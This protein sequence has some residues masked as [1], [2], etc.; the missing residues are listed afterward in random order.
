MAWW[1]ITRLVTF[2]FTQMKELLKTDYLMKNGTDLLLT[3]QR[4]Y[5]FLFLAHYVSD[6]LF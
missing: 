5:F 6:F 2:G 1:D 4:R 3:L